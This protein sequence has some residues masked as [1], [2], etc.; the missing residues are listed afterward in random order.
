M[1]FEAIKFKNMT[2]IDIQE[3]YDK[4][5]EFNS[6][7]AGD[8]W[9]NLTEVAIELLDNKTYEIVKLVIKPFTERYY[10]GGF[11]KENMGTQLKTDI[12]IDI[13]HDIT[14]N[15][16]FTVDE[17]IKKYYKKYFKNYLIQIHK[18]GYALTLNRIFF[19]REEDKD[20]IQNLDKGTVINLV[21]GIDYNDNYFYINNDTT[22]GKAIIENREQ[23]KDEVN[24]NIEIIDEKI[25]IRFCVLPIILP[26]MFM[27]PCV[28][29]PNNYPLERMFND[30]DEDIVVY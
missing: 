4:A 17:F 12:L 6:T 8:N 10:Y 25:K 11:N 28:I 29:F 16:E 18:G 14:N 9:V 21:N 13:I 7:F 3:E 5:P 24:I 19:I 1:T 23:I 30:N 2:I 26:I 27:A 22:L 20:E 15:I